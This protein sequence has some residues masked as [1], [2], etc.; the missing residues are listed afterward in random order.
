MTHKER[1][2]TVLSK[3]GPIYEIIVCDECAREALI[4]IAENGRTK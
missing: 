1:K 4:W 3:D 2:E